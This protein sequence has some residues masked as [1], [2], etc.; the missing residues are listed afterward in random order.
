MH[1]SETAVF[2]VKGAK[3]QT[4]SPLFHSYPF[5]FTAA[6]LTA[7]PA[8]PLCFY[9]PTSTPLAHIPCISVSPIFNFPS[10]VFSAISTRLPNLCL[11]S[12]FWCR[13][14]TR[15]EDVWAGKWTS[16]QWPTGQPDH[17][18]ISP[19]F[20]CILR[21]VPHDQENGSSGYRFCNPLLTFLAVM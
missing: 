16:H 2:K 13:V 3:P 6:S 7:I 8:L 9:F 17:L 14:G 1:N 4:P 11:S 5:H 10:P 12:S 18:P 19:V 20:P 15:W 21:S